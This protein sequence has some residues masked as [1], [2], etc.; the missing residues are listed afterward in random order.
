MPRFSATHDSLVG[1]IMWQEIVRALVRVS[2]VTVTPKV[3]FLLLNI[4]I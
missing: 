3:H 2:L 1:K 4:H